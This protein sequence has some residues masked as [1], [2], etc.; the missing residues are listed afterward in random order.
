[1]KQ[2]TFAFTLFAILVS[3][4]WGLGW[5]SSHFNWVFLWP[6]LV[7]GCF[8]YVKFMPFAKKNES[9][10][11]TCLIAACC[12]P[13]NCKIA[14]T[15]FTSWDLKILSLLCQVMTWSFLLSI[16]IIIALYINR[17]LGKKRF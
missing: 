6:I 16:E 2:L 8:L 15:Y 7:L 4:F 5:L 9:L 14:V 17:R 10:W 13:W 3:P 11:L 12:I 1:M